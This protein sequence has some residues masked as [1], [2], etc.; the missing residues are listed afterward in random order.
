MG[1]YDGPY[2]RIGTSGEFIAD[3]AGRVQLFAN[4]AWVMYWNNHGAIEA[5]IRK[6]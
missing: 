3:R 4:D 6:G 5:D 2:H 1:Q